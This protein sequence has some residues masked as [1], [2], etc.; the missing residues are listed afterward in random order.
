MTQNRIHATLHLMNVNGMYYA[1]N[2]NPSKAR[3]SPAANQ[4][5]RRN[6]SIVNLMRRRWQQARQVPRDEGEGMWPLV[7]VT[8][9][10]RK[11]SQL[12]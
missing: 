6:V 10:I 5:H 1:D 9:V 3:L 12:S 4:Q 7:G 2:E 8:C 11:D